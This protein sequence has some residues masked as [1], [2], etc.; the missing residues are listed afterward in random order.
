MHEIEPIPGVKD[1]TTL[2]EVIV[3]PGE[4]K[5]ALAY[6]KK[7]ETV[8]KAINDQIK[9]LGT[10]KE[11]ETLKNQG[12]VDR[13]MARETL[14]KARE[15]LAAA[16][17]TASGIITDAEADADKI[18]TAAKIAVSAT[19]EASAG[20]AS[21]LVARERKVSAR[22]KAAKKREDENDRLAATLAESEG[23]IAEQLKRAESFIEGR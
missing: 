22:E 2:L 15:K 8:R 17:L 1:A 18:E 11:I 19:A 6:L 16:G 13:Q 23:V 20:V 10:I 21:D 7:L 14:V 3:H 9:T 5:N 12:K 4:A